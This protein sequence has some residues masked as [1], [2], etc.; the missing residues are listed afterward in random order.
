MLNVGHSFEVAGERGEFI[1]D[2]VEFEELLLLAGVEETERRV[3]SVTEHATLAAVGERKLAESGFVGGGAR[4]RSF[5][6][7]H[8]DLRKRSNEVTK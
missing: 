7:F 2:V 6:G 4:A 8:G 5:C 3:R 1:A